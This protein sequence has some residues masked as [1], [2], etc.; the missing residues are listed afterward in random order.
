MTLSILSVAATA[1]LEKS[2]IPETASSPMSSAT[3]SC[4]TSTASNNADS[5]EHRSV[6]SGESVYS[7]VFIKRKREDGEEVGSNEISCESAGDKS[8]N[9]SVNERSEVTALHEHTPNGVAI[10]SFTKNFAHTGFAQKD[11]IYRDQLR[12][13]LMGIMQ[14]HC[15]GGG[16]YVASRLRGLKAKYDVRLG[17]ESFLERRTSF[18]PGT[19]EAPCDSGTPVA[20]KKAR[21]GQKKL[22]VESSRIYPSL[23]TSTPAPPTDENESKMSILL[24]L[25]DSI[26]KDKIDVMPSKLLRNQLK[27]PSTREV[28][29]RRTVRGKYKQRMKYASPPGTLVLEGSIGAHVMDKDGKRKL[30]VALLELVAKYF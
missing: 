18:V 28:P 26:S 13:V 3:Y 4:S 29:R 9:E 21:L 2:L 1:E 14:K 24:D 27:R 10:D 5:V 19:G 17:D 16:R 15:R 7:A 11:K 23:P 8:D 6:H 12:N 20:S 25:I 22:K 30:L